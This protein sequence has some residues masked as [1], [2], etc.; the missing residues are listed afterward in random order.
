[1]S[2]VCLDEQQRKNNVIYFDFLIMYKKW[3]LSAMTLKCADCRSM[4]LSSDNNISN[5]ETEKAQI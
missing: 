5:D 1:M 3:I 4:A 2:A